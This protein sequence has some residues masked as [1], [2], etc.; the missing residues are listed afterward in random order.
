M[1]ALN[2]KYSQLFTDDYGTIRGEQAT[3]HLK[4]ECMPEFR[5]TRNLPFSLRYALEKE[6]ENVE[7]LEVFTTVLRSLFGTPIVPVVKKDGSVPLCGDYH[8]TLNAVPEAEQH[9][10][11]RVRSAGKLFSKLDLNR[12]YN[13]NWTW[14]KHLESTHL[15]AL[16]GVVPGKSFGI[17]SSFSSCRV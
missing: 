10:L 2:T 1:A 16:M 8:T 7:W 4:K 17:W 11:P 14:T 5:K 12:A 9:P 6:V 15:S 3:P 13:T